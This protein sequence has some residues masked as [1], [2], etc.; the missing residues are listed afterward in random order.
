M[1]FRD[2]ATYDERRL[3]MRGQRRADQLH[4]ELDVVK[5]AYPYTSTLDGDLGPDGSLAGE[6]TYAPTALQAGVAC[7]LLARD[8]LHVQRSTQIAT[9]VIAL[10]RD[11]THIWASTTGDDWLLLNHDATPAGQVVVIYENSAH[12]TSSAVTFDGARLWGFLPVTIIDLEGFHNRSRLLEFTPQ[13]QIVGD[14]ML[15]HRTVGLAWDGTDFWSLDSGR[16]T[17]YRF[18]RSAAILDSLQLEVPDPYHLE[19]DGTDFWTLGWY[20]NNLYRIDASGHTLAV[21]DLPSPPNSG[22]PTGLVFDGTSMWY[23]WGEP[24]G[25]ASRLYA[26]DLPPP[27]V[28]MRARA[29]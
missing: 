25:G 4:L 11:G 5:V 6:L 21:Y 26:F 23:A 24:F 10:G 15:G 3:W 18:D 29:R 28:P 7:R 12:W 27:V 17:L 14:A 19:F 13:G 22:D 20:V 2:R 1:V 9:N 16:A 8:S